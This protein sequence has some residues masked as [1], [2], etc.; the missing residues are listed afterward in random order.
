MAFAQRKTSFSPLKS[1]SYKNISVTLYED[2]IEINTNGAPAKLSR[3]EAIGWFKQLYIHLDK[4]S[5]WAP[6]SEPE[7]ATGSPQRARSQTNRDEVSGEG[8][9][10]SIA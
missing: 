6:R 5:S 3:E 10:F 2:G 7:M 4:R 9:E 1:I 8:T